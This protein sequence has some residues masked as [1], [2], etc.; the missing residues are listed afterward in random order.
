MEIYEAILREEIMHRILQLEL[1]FAEVVEGRCYR[2]IR[3]IYAIVSDETLDDPECFR[4]V[5]EIVC[6]LEE[7]GIGGGGRHDF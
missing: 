7:L 1:N 3:Q 6:A 4:R 2:A 5:E